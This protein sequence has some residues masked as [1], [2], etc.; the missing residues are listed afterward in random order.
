MNRFLLTLLSSPVL[1]SSALSLLV[2]LQPAAAQPE[3]SPQ[4]TCAG[5]A[6]ANRRLVCTRITNET[7]TD[8]KQI[9]NLAKPNPDQPEML[10]FTEEESDAAVALFGC[11]CP[12]CLNALRQL[13]N[14][15]PLVR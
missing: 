14:L 10:E 15:P 4:A 13:R 1:L 2:A 11:D 7:G 12:T 6:Q 3:R 5:D 9:V 8:A